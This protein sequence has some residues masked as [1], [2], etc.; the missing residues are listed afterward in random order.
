MEVALVGQA[1]YAVV[2]LDKV[3]LTKALLLLCPSA[4]WQPAT[5]NAKPDLLPL[6]VLQA[7]G[8]VLAPVPLQPAQASASVSLAPT[9]HSLPIWRR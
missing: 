5:N 9:S 1:K 6:Y 8:T 3:I 2:T 7:E 4:I